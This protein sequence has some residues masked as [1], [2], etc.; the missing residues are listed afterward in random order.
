[1]K[2]FLLLI[3]AMLTGCASVPRCEQYEFSAVIA[4]GIVGGIAAGH[5]HHSTHQTQAATPAQATVV[6]HAIGTHDGITQQ[7]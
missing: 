2:I 7:P 5:H 6:F 4:V 3:V 1:M